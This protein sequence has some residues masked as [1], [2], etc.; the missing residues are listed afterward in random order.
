MANDVKIQKK[1]YDPKTFNKVVDRN[2]K[3]YAQKPDPVLETTVEEFFI[4]YE[5]LFYIKYPYFFRITIKC[6]KD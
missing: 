4:L 5:E 2:F 3:T 1:V 6:L